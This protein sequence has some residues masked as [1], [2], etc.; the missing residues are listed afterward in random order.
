[1][2]ATGTWVRWNLNIDLICF[3]LMAKD[4]E[5]FFMYLL[6]IVLLLKSICLAHLN[7][8]FDSWLFNFLSSL[9]SLDINAP[10]DE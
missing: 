4:G 9:Y 3:F 10:S 1:M 5:H 8:L 7:G 2:L 6:A